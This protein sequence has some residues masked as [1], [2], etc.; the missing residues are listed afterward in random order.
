MKRND[1]LATSLTAHKDM[2]M[3]LTQ[4][5][6]KLSVGLSAFCIISTAS[7]AYPLWTFT[8]NPN[9]PS[10][11]SINS[12]QTATVVYS[13]QNQSRKSKWL[14]IQPITGVG[15]SFPCRLTPY[16]QPGS[17]CSLILAVTGN[18]LPKE[19][20]H[21]GPILCEANSNGT[22]NPNQ[23]YRPSAPDNLNI[24]LTNPTVGV[25]ITVNP[26]ILLIA[27]H[28]T[29]TVTVI[30]E[31]SSSASAN[32]VIA[33]IPNG[34]GISI[35]STTCGSSLSIGANCTITFAS[36]T[37]EGPT[38]I[39]VKGDNTNT[40]NVYAAVTDQPLISITG[41]AQQSRIVSTDGF[42]AL[43]LEITN[44]SDSIFNANNITV[45]DKTSC[46]NLSVDASNCTS[47]APGASCQL[48]LTTTTPY[49]PCTITISGSNTGNSPTTLVA[50]SHLGGLV[51]QKSGTNG[52]V[53]VDAGSEF[54]SAWTFPSKASI[55]GAF[56]D[57]DGV[58]NTNAIVANS[59]CTNQTGN[60]AAYRCRAISADW[61]LPAKNELQ[62]VIFALCPGSAY[63]CAFGAFSSTFYWSSTQWFAD[64]NAYSVDVP[65]GNYLPGDKWSSEPVRCIRDF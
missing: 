53:V 15:Q 65:D 38:I 26:F 29:G 13:V 44:D 30:N 57:D 42:T 41:P 3:K 7:A 54:T 62:A 52:K 34:S 49:A 58:G 37:Q 55:P 63:P 10:K 14:V 60:C 8:P 19:G 25:T 31:A 39:P 36:T 11:V 47:V 51:F 32:N 16:G 6:R 56:S 59:A 40:A 27:E 24:T 9:Y 1:I 2:K 50:F 21:T 22:P 46:P 4:F 17:S 20:V 61:Y 33:T 28:S 64:T 23:C 12:S 48:A 45:S 18:Q 5:I 35:Q 43:D